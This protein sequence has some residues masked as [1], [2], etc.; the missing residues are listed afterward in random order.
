MVN[1]NNVYLKEQGLTEH[2]VKELTEN[3][4]PPS[5]AD[6]PAFLLVVV[7]PIYEFVY[8][9]GNVIVLYPLVVVLPHCINRRLLI[10]NRHIIKIH[11][12]SFILHTR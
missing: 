8:V 9:V 3:P 10:S 2:V 12:P 5:S 7:K 4:L 6:A 1:Q 11:A